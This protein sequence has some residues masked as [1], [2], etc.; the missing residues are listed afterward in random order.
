MEAPT[1][2]T[3]L[4]LPEVQQQSLPSS[5]DVTRMSDPASLARQLLASANDRS[6]SLEIALRCYCGVSQDAAP[7]VEET[8]EGPA[9]P[10][11]PPIPELLPGDDEDHIIAGAI[12]L[13]KY[14]EEV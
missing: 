11:P 14:F 13:I 12:Q 2:Y 9:S 1:L 5:I 10:L 6:T 7:V 8:T 3:P 4:R